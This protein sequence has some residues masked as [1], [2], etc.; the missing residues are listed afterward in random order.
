MPENN[1]PVTADNMTAKERYFLDW[2]RSLTDDQRRTVNHSLETGEPFPEDIVTTMPPEMFTYEQRRDILAQM[3]PSELNR[4][5]WTLD[6][7]TSEGEKL[8]ES[9]VH[10]A[11]IQDQLHTSEIMALRIVGDMAMNFAFTRTA[12]FEEG[13]LEALVN[14]ISRSIQDTAAHFSIPLE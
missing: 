6:L 4:I 12:L 1:N 13:N 14:S 11:H 5:E 10:T 8:P 2:Y 3:T 9:I 7:W